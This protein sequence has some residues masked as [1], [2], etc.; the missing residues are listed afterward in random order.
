MKNTFPKIR[1]KHLTVSFLT[2]ILLYLPLTAIASSLY[3][4]R[5]EYAERPLSVETEQPVFSWKTKSSRPGYWQ[6]SYRLQVMQGSM[7]I[8]DSGEVL[9]D[10]SAGI[11][12]GGPG[13]A[14]AT[15]YRWRVR[16]QSTAGEK[17]P[18]SDWQEFA[19]GLHGES[20]WAPSKWIAFEADR[21][22][23]RIVPGIHN[24]WQAQ[25]LLGNRKA[26][27][28]T[29]PQIRKS[30][31]L[32]K[33]IRRATVYACGLGHFELFLN[34][35]KVGNHFLDAGWTLYDREALYVAFDVS[36][37]VH[38]GM[39]AAGVMLGGGFYDIPRD[40]YFKVLTSFGAPKLRLLLRVEYRD[41]SSETIGSDETWRATAGP[42]TFSS[43]FGGEDYDAAQAH[44]GWVAPDYDDSDW[45]PVVPTRYE[46]RLRAQTADPVTVR[47]EI[48]P[49]RRFRNAAGHWVYDF[50]QNFSGIVSVCVHGERGQSLVLRPGELLN[51]DGSV[52][53]SA[54]GD[55]Y[56]FT[57]TLAGGHTEQW[58]PQ[59]TYYGFR[60]VQV[61][62]AVP[63]EEA[64]PDGRPV[65]EHLKG[66]HT[67][68]A[69]PEAGTFEC[70]DTLMNR[71]HSLIDWAVRSNMQSVLTDCPHREKLGWI[72]QAHLMQPSLLYR[73]DLHRL[74]GKIF[75]DMQT[76][77]RAD[78]CIPS[79]TPEYVRFADG[80]EDSPEWGS[81][82]I[83]SPWYLYQTY[84]DT[85]LI[86]KHYPAMK[87]YMEYLAGRAVDGIVAYGLGDWY[88]IGPN[89]PG[90]AQLTSNGVTATAICYYDA[91]LMGRMAEMLGQTED[92]AR[93]DSIQHEL[94]EAFHRKFVHP[95]TGMVERGSQTACAI[96]LFTGILH[97]NLRPQV[98]QQ[99]I[100]DIRNRNN[101]LT[102]GDIGFRYV[103]GSLAQAGRSDVVYDMNS[104]SDTPGYGW[105]LAHGATALTESWQAYGFVSN[106][107]FM[108][109][110]LMEWLYAWLGGIRQQENSSG[111][112][113]IL[114]APQPVGGITR[115]NTSYESPYG[116]ISCRWQVSPA[117]MLTVDVVI[118]P[119]SKA[120]ILLPG[121]SKTHEVGSGSYRFESRLPAVR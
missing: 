75:D 85:T 47:N 89:P 60:Y 84:G 7:L 92:V 19:T 113:N 63:E 23:A 106:N 17:S 99:L 87:R 114:I 53:Q 27:I 116:R 90:Y 66:L 82:F 30:F 4:L 18:W 101:A 35:S 5:C 12:Y 69:A 28:Y 31:T 40:R 72:E 107:H 73:Y 57:Y 102:A 71:I 110:H 6:K 80:F 88:D 52:N 56:F 70:S 10:Q 58:Q 111:F 61:E 81:A 119:N 32:R 100:D 54:S 78:G 22:D 62:G 16:T 94:R 44:D 67:C 59:F 36:R 55:P 15:A 115:A 95:E 21:P 26:G 117:G 39:N 34:G 51:P 25:S 76:S 79:I 103:L 11:P 1:R 118:P 97:E 83:I 3:A 29:L 121:E 49:V 20:D 38:P 50:G 64:N 104:R 105:Q 65:L 14:P 96:A 9:S 93:F 41:G 68:N 91:V 112:R 77:Q 24:D 46:G 8:W 42:V 13:L 33:H 45:Q 48:A 120:R 98:L 74:Y 109:G 108:L 43:I 2:F 37:W 86:R